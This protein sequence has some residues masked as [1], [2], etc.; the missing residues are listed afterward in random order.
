MGRLIQYVIAATKDEIE[1]KLLS[2]SGVLCIPN[3]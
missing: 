3:L 1:D 2:H